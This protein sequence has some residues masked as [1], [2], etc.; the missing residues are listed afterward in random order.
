V[1]NFAKPLNVF[2]FE[3]NSQNISSKK[4]VR[5]DNNDNIKA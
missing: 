4:W 2:Y 3:S 1:K 5:N